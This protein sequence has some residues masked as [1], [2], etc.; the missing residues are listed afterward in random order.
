MG[1]ASTEGGGL[2][3]RPSSEIDRL[4]A[5]GVVFG[6]SGPEDSTS[7]Y[8]S[9]LRWLAACGHQEGIKRSTSSQMH[10][11]DYSSPASQESRI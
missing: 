9:A 10:Y 4:D 2:A 3:K 6:Q 5:K 1:V 8:G 7:K 11:G